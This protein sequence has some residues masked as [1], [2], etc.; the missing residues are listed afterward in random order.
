[1]Y[2]SSQIFFFLRTCTNSSKRGI[3]E[4]ET[5]VL[6]LC[7][8]KQ[9]TT[10][11]CHLWLFLQT[12]SFIFYENYQNIHDGNTGWKIGNS[13]WIAFY[14][15]SSNRVTKQNGKIKEQNYIPQHI[16]FTTVFIS[17]NNPI[18]LYF[19]GD[20]LLFQGHDYKRACH[21]RL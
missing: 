2:C 17:K 21:G 4:L 3:C 7:I 16:L 10:S 14:L 18:L 15:R 6:V 19:K 13:V 9:S 1:M 8:L 12:I 5:S 11:E 20:K